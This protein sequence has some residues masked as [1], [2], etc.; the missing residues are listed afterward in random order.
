[1]RRSPSA[2]LRRLLPLSFLL[3]ALLFLWPLTLQPNAI[4]FNPHSDVTDLLVT[5]LPNAHYIR[6]SLQRYGQLP[7]WNAHIMSGQPLA[8]D[9]LAGLW[10]PPNVLLL[11]PGLPLPVVFNGLLIFHVAWAGFGLFSFLR[12]EGLSVGAALVGGVAFVGAPKVIAH[13]AAGHVSLIFAIAWTPWL[14]RALQ[15][16]IRIGGLKS[17]ARAGACLALIFVADVRWAFYAGVLGVAWW[18]AHLPPFAARQPLGQ[19]ARATLAFTFL[20]LLLIA[21]LALPLAE[22]LLYSGREALTLTEA[23]EFSLPPSYLLGVLILDPY[24]FHEYLTYVGLPTLLLALLGLRRVTLF[25]WLLSVGAAAFA[26]GAHFIVFPL[27]FNFLP[28]LSFL[29]VPSRAWFLVALAV[30]TLAAYGVQRSITVAKRQHI[31]VFVTLLSLV[32]IDLLRASSTLLVAR[33]LPAPTSATAWLAGQPGLFRVYAPRYNLPQPDTLQ[34]AEGVDPL[35]L[36]AYAEFMAQASGIPR[37][38]YSVVV[39]TLIEDESEAITATT[40]PD[41]RLLGLL[42]VRFV[43]SEFP[44]QTSGFV[45]K[46]TFDRTRIYENTLARP[47]AW[48]PTGEAEIQ[49]WSPNRI[50]VRATGP[51][52]LTLSEIAYPGW[53]ATIDGRHANIETVEGIL[54]AVSLTEGS[55]IIVFEFHPRSVYIGAG[56]TAVGLLALLGLWRW[57]K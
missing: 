36:S 34:H 26:L 31:L 30:A 18:L 54:R 12:A 7:L 46:Q 41:A 24:G 21:G 17:G 51:G 55:H 5:H 57:A 3:F 49:V 19:Q 8:A 15:R 47:R 4:P 9:P 56:L 33:P 22:F 16:V 23:S 37:L 38:G 43:V 20:F 45:L 52:Q 14:L 35:Y 32:S 29:R 2:T 13:I 10:Y 11:L 53:Q 40:S 48:T 28:G 39:P 50:R 1:M 42:N 44:L 25:W 27:L 6:D